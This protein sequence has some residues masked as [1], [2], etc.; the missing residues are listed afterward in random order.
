MHTDRETIDAAYASALT[1]ENVNL[2]LG[3]C[4]L[5]AEQDNREDA[6][7]VA[8]D[9]ITLLEDCSPYVR[10]VAAKILA[11]LG[12]DAA[13]ALPALSKALAEKTNQI[14]NRYELDEEIDWSLFDKPVRDLQNQTVSSAVSSAM[15][16]IQSE[17]SA[18]QTSLLAKES[19]R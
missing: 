10:T 16:A 15:A 18:V 19:S 7:E 13:S 1:S 9:M 11:G 4:L 12:P 3:A 17:A 14:P 2:R 6:E 8:W 5:L